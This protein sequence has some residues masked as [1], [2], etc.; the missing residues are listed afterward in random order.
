MSIDIIPLDTISLAK[1]SLSYDML[2]INLKSPSANSSSSQLLSMSRRAIVR[3]RCSTILGRWEKKA[4]IFAKMITS[5]S[6]SYRFE[7][8]RSVSSA[9]FEKRGSP[10]GLRFT[11][12]SF[13]HINWRR[14]PKCSIMSFSLEILFYSILIPIE[15][16]LSTS[17]SRTEVIIF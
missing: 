5:S 13:E 10:K 17:S 11:I 3:S 4:A 7:V 14:R 9:R 6:L 12:K 1:S 2:H 16:A 8:S 15:T